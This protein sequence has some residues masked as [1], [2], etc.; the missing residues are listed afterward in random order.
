MQVAGSFSHRAAFPA[1]TIF[2]SVSSA[3]RDRG[4]EGSA[5]PLNPRY[6]ECRARLEQG[7]LENDVGGHP[8]GY[9]PPTVDLSDLQTIPFSFLEAVGVTP[10]PARYDRRDLGRLTPVRDQGNCGSCRTFA[11]MSS[12]E[13]S[14]MPDALARSGY[15]GTPRQQEPDRHA[16]APAHSMARVREAW[17]RERDVGRTRGYFEDAIRVSREISRVMNTNRLYPERHRQWSAVRDELNRLAG[18]FDLPPL[19]WD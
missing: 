7:T 13:C 6:L 19:R 8:P 5:A 15:R 16:D 14:L 12:A 1:A 2:F 18:A 11:T 9:V 4:T 17:N 10:L 3:A